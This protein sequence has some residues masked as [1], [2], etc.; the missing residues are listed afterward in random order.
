MNPRALFAILYGS[1][2][3]AAPIAWSVDMPEKILP[4]TV[5]ADTLQAFK[6]K[7]TFTIT[8]HLNQLLGSDGSLA[9]IKGKTG[10]GNE[11]LAFYLMYE[12]TG[13][14]RFRKAAL[15]LADQVL[16]AMRATK[17]GVLPIKEKE[18]PGGRT[19]IG[20]GPP[21]LGAYASDVAYILHKEGGRNDDLLFIATVLDK[22][23]WNE[24]GWWAADIDVTTGESKEPLSKPSPVN[25]TAA[26]AMAAGIVSGYVQDI[27][28][29]L[30]ARLKQK[31]D[32]C[33]YRQIIPAQLTDGFWHYSL[34]GNDPKNKDILGY[35][36]LTLGELM[37]LQKF[38]PAYRDVKLSATIKKAQA[39]AFQ[40]IAPMTEPNSGS[41]CPEHTT[42]ETP[43]HYSLRE[44][45]KRSFQLGHI[46]IAGG[47][48]A[49][50]IKIME[51][52]LAYFPIGNTGQDGAHAAEPTVLI[53]SGN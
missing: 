53:L 7:L 10:E 43:S 9:N 35:F 34:S 47:Y 12:K 36:M 22:Y 8:N 39:F 26:I 27:A 5:P 45:A 46:L 29:E 11:A 4:A 40:C 17:S 16:K 20:G 6:L 3:L 23:P 51:A 24:G 19:I 14:Q 48:L 13:E 41:A 32:K 50:G 15:N 37:K 31:T 49:E 38:N 21:A 33:L 44:N 18:Q 30:A 1:L 2:L 25:K 28:P 42:R 52:A